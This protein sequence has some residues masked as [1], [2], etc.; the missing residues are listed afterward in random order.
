MNVT[1]STLKERLVDQINGRRV[2]AALFY[3]FNFDPKFFENYVMPILVPSQTFINNSIANNILWRKLY[4]DNAVPAITVYFDQDAKSTDNGP[5]LDYKLVAVSMPM[6]GKN[7]GNFHPKHSFILVENTGAENELI[8]ITGS[9]NITQSGWCENIECISEKMLINGKEFP[10]ELR[11]SIKSFIE[12]TYR[13][14]GKLWTIAE[15]KI[16]SYLNKIGYTNEREIYLFNSF[17]GDFQNFIDLNILNDDSIHTLEICS[18]Y[19]KNTPD[20]LKLIGDKKIKIKIQAPF[21]NGYCFLDQ[22]VYD[23]YKQQGVKWYYQADES[24]NNHSKVYRFYGSTKTYTIIGSVNLTA[25]A[26]NGF[27]AKPKQIFNIESAL[28]YVQKVDT[29]NYILKKEIKEELKFSNGATTS[30]E[31]HERYEVPDIQFVIDWSTKNL[32]WKNASKNKC[33]LEIFNQKFDLNSSKSVDLSAL[34]NA[35]LVIESIARKPLL[36]VIETMEKTEREHYYYANQIGFEK[37]PL[38]FRFSSTDIIDAWELLG[39][40]SSELNDWL[41][42]RLEQVTDIMQDESGILISDQTVEKSLLNEMARHF[43]GL[44][45]LEQFLYDDSVLNKSKPQKA[46][47]FKNFKYYLTYD[48]IDTLFSYYREVY[49]LKHDGKILSVYYWLLL[50]ILVN[51]FYGA[52][53]LKKFLKQI[54]VED[55]EKDSDI[56]K[57]IE[58][59]R[60][61]IE[62]EIEMV[63][64]T[65]NVDK[66]KM[67]WAL[68]ILNTDHEL[69]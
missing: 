25:P 48:N 42:N 61:E 9:N 40:E 35:H 52:T 13:N 59:I 50:N 69:Y 64:K 38:E 65:L 17:Q 37:R 27:A 30:E 12:A 11:K 39:N 34:K 54:N 67:K 43:Y 6:V 57:S 28:L 26:W 3:T 15:D 46:S 14:Y 16:F 44:V 20:L 21:R 47:H 63:G 33:I 68:S 1:D 45:K 18:P 58:E 19:F 51:N 7:K 2:I 62:I 66:R 36:K 10:R 24:R 5:Y 55:L 41:V 56:L 4:K 32:S 49:R 53:N 60:N 23:S 22:N 29:Q 31:W 8:V